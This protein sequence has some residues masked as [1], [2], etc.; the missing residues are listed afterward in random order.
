MEFPPHKL[1]DNLPGRPTPDAYSSD[2]TG[3]VIDYDEFCEACS[4][5]AKAVPLDQDR[6]AELGQ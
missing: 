2:F 3:R 6:G 1:S 5:K 4:T